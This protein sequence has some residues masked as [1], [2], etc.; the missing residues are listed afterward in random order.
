VTGND[1]TLRV[2][3]SQEA[4]RCFGNW[5]PVSIIAGVPHVATPAGE[6]CTGCGSDIR[7]DDLGL[8]VN[9]EYREDYHLDDTVLINPADLHIYHSE[10]DT[11]RHMTLTEE[12]Q[13][14]LDAATSS[15]GRRRAAVRLTTMWRQSFN[16]DKYRPDWEG[17]W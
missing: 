7:P 9:P 12:Q 14:E 8:Y 15:L 10:C 1:K 3:A 4:I 6:T 11:L 2:P 5:N 13:A 17:G 16:V